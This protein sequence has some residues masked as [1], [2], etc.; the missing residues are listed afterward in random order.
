LSKFDL[1]SLCKGATF[2]SFKN[3]MPFKGMKFTV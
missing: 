1:E 3:V 2:Q